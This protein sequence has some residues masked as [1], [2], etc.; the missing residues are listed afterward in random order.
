[1]WMVS[2]RNGSGDLLTGFF[3]PIQTGTAAVTVPAPSGTMR[4]T[5]PHKQWWSSKHE[6]AAMSHGR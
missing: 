4:V 1:M 5:V 2:W 3:V 6:P